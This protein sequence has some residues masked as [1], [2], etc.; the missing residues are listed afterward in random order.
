[1]ELTAIDVILNGIRDTL[2]PD[3]IDKEEVKI[4]KE[5]DER[6]KEYGTNG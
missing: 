1:M 2:E 5:K 4:L 3:G 6:R